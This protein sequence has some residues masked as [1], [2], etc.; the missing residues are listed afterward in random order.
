MER[1]LTENEKISRRATMIKGGISIT[2]VNI[3]DDDLGP[4]VV[5]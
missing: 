2:P 3:M 1:T 5:P 4:V